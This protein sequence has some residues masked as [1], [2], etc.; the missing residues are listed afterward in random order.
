MKYIFILLVTL[1]SMIAKGQSIT[2]SGSPTQIQY[3]KGSYKADRLMVLP[4]TFIPFTSFDSTGSVWFD[5]AGTKTLWF[6]NGTARVQLASGGGSGSVTSV[7]GGGY[8]LG[9]TITTFGTLTPDTSA[10]KLATKTD[11]NSYYLA[12]NPN[13]YITSASIAGKMNYTDTPSML[14]PYL[15]KGDSG[16][17]YYSKYGVDT[18]KTAIRGQIP[19]NNNQ[20]T[21]GAGYITGNQNITLSGDVTGSGTTA[22]TTT[23][24]NS[25]VTAGT[26]GSTSAIPVITVDAKG[27][28]TTITTVGIS[29]GAG[30]VTSVSVATANGFAG[31]VA[32]P[33]TTPVITIRTGVTGILN[34]TGTGVQA[35]VAGDFPTLNQST[36]GTAS[37]VTGTV[38][39][40][41]GGTGATSFT[42]GSIPFMGASTLSQDNSDFF[43]DAANMRL[44]IQTNAPATALDVRG[45]SGGTGSVGAVSIAQSW[46]GA[47]APT[48]FKVAVSDASSST[49]KIFDFLGGA[50]GTTS[51]ASLD[52][53]GNM[54]VQNSLAVPNI[55]GSIAST[56]LGIRN[57]T[58][59][60][61]T[62]NIDLISVFKDRAGTNVMTTASTAGTTNEFAIYPTYAQGTGATTINN[63]L[64]VDRT[65]TTIGTGT[66]QNL[67]NLKKGGVSQFKVSNLGNITTLGRLTPRDGNTTSS[68]TPTINT[69][70]VDQYR[71]TAQAVD[72][73]SFTTNLSGTPVEGQHLIISIT[74]TAARAIT[75]GASFEA[76]TVALPTTTV[77]TNM[78]SVLFIYNSVT[79]KWRCARTW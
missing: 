57:T 30:T 65:E 28:A 56:A 44:G 6:H 14:A 26:Y 8:M 45:V 75:W 33:T 27:R 2:P 68:A 54:I 5:S 50:S 4:R 24:A 53:N 46:S 22:I 73:T 52:R 63:D 1:I 16:I 23:L 74:G 72:I 25:G 13:G 49:G 31:T 21:N 79:S 61:S 12:S 9:G 58:A 78:L 20:L 66:E 69:D 3:N 64:L 15:R 39:I 29:A 7:T 60:T 36:T 19:T 35:A 77:T 34:G 47:V 55:Y 40:A 70:L 48:A 62:N 41:N 76:S 10:G 18:A 71:L 17:V 51:R 59:S 38:A 32:T 42:T 67:I 37:N 11:L 43:W